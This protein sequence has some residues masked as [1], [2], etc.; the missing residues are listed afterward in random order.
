LEFLLTLNKSWFYLFTDHE[1]IWLRESEP[2]LKGKEHDS[3]TEKMITIAL[4]P[5]SFHVVEALPKGETFNAIYYIEHILQPT[6][7]YRPKSGLRQLIIHVDNARRYTARKSRIFYKSNSLRI[8]PH[9]PY[10][11]DLTH[12]YFFGYVKHCLN[13]ASF[14]SK[15]ELLFEI[16]NIEK[17]ISWATLI[18]TF[19][20]WIEILAWIATN[21]GNYYQ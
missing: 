20:N 7:E 6:L 16:G 10:S 4:N 17:S 18:A 8:A 11:P 21:E 9:P 15:D 1:I 2:P 3:S 19:Q 5:H 14:N 12:L 13:E